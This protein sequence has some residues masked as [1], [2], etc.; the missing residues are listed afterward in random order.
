M[1]VRLNLSTA[2]LEN[3]R[4]FLFSAVLLG[5]LGAGAFGLL[6]HHVYTHWRADRALREEVARLEREIRQFR[7]QRR[8][9]EAYFARPE[10]RLLTD[11][12]AFLNALIEQRGFPWT[13]VFMDL[14]RLLP[15][16]VRVVS[17]APRMDAGRVEVKFVVGA[18]SDE[19]KLKFLRTLDSAEVFSRVQVLSETRPARP[20]ENDRILLELMAWYSAT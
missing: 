19:S 15:E 12:A 17:I 6:S 1:K 10:T 4:R 20:V 9:L 8:E 3:N 2:P 14:E 11:R 18:A 16:G 13:K 5:V 7:E